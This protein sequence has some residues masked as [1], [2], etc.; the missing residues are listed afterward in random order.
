MEKGGYWH[1]QFPD[2]FSN[3]FQQELELTIYHTVLFF[4]AG[5]SVFHGNHSMDS[6][7]NN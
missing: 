2:R 4:S 6:H 1:K 3:H 7:K 5:H